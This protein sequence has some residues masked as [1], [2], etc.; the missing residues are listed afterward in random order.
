MNN[1]RYYQSKVVK[2]YIIFLS[3]SSD[4][5]VVRIVLQKSSDS[6]IRAICNAALNAR[7]DDVRIPPHLKHIFAKYHKHIHRL[8][9]RRCRLVKK[10]RLLV[11]RGG[12]PPIIAP[13]IAIVLGLIGGEFISRLF[14]KNE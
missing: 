9:D 11:Q 4:T 7:V 10:R 8:T 13:L 6:V 2:R 14:H 5:E 12:V 3:I 1:K